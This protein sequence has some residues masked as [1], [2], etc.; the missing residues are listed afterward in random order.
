MRLT[1]LIISLFFCCSITAQKKLLKYD[2]STVEVRSANINTYKN[3][4][5][6]QY[7]IPKA[8]TESLWDRFWR[9]FWESI[10][11]IR[12]TKS[13]KTV[14]DSIV[15]IV[16]VAAIIFF[17]W[18]ITGMNATGILG[19]NDSSINYSIGTDDINA[20]DFDAAIEDSVSKLN[21]IMAVRLLYLQTLK[22]LSDTNIIEWKINKTNA[23]YITE[24]NNHPQQSGFRY[25]TGVFDYVWYGNKKIDKEEFVQ[26]HQL[27]KQFQQAIVSEEL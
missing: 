14:L 11:E 7:K 17:I 15:I 19:R 27:F 24:L 13:G 2:T 6:F 3:Q 5:A 4:K 22:I 21:Y 1:L 26:V 20:I 25:L 16:A 8:P 10:D 18:K 9:W 12:K 23:N